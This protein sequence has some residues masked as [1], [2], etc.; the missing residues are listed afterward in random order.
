MVEP[1][2]PVPISAVL[3]S[4]AGT[5]TIT[6][7]QMIENPLPAG[8][9]GGI[10]N[11]NFLITYTSWAVTGGNAI[12]AT[13]ADTVTADPGPDMAFMTVPPDGVRGLDGTPA[14]G[15]TGFP[16]TII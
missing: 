11:T 7:D 6:F 13:L 14:A 5:F 10:R 3:N 1:D 8:V 15:F 4:G 16:L 2:P 12:V 9:I